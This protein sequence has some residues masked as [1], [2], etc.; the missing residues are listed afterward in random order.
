MAHSI[1]FHGQY[2][3]RGTTAVGNLGGLASHGCIRLSP[4]A[5]ATLFAM[6]KKQG[7][8]IRIVGSHLNDV[9]HRQGLGIGAWVRADPPHADAQAMGARST[10]AVRPQARQLPAG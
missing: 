2:A 8:E 10:R 1:F 3:M 7:A 4:G 6:V 9:A 5:A